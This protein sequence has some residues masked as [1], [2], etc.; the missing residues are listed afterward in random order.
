MRKLNA[1][2]NLIITMAINRE[3]INRFTERTVLDLRFYLPT[4]LSLPKYRNYTQVYRVSSDRSDVGYRRDNKQIVIV[5]IL[6]IRSWFIAS[7]WLTGTAMH[8]HLS[9]P[10]AD[11]S[12]PSECPTYHTT[13]PSCPCNLNNINWTQTSALAAAVTWW[14]GDRFGLT[15]WDK[16][17]QYKYR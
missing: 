7:S 12:P 3:S 13:L 11:D 15:V 6:R 10:I 17:L 1:L 4:L 2:I 9:T 8:R 16:S 5:V 14:L